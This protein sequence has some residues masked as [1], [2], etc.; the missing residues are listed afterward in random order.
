VE[1]GDWLRRKTRNEGMDGRADGRMGGRKNG[2]KSGRK[3][4]RKGGRK[5]GQK[6]G[7]KDGRKDGRL[8]N[9][10]VLSVCV[11]NEI[12]CREPGSK[13]SVQ[14]ESDLTKKKEVEK[15]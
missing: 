14:I 3:S 8:Q 5:D 15:N 11:Q 7:R 10:R 4:G 9:E 12:V 2:R 1:K 6:G 13:M